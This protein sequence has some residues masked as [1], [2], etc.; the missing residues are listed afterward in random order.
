MR[1]EGTG[2]R[3]ELCDCVAA[4]QPAS[5]ALPAVGSSPAPH[6]TMFSKHVCVHTSRDHL[7]GN[8][9]MKKYAISIFSVIKFE[10]DKGF[11]LI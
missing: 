3:V 5:G 9:R 7:S 6:Q 11:R 10:A 2:R 8:V 4:G 1:T